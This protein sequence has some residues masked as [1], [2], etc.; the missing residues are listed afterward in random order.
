MSLVTI[1]NMSCSARTTLED[2]YPNLL[3]NNSTNSTNFIKRSGSRAI[4]KFARNVFLEMLPSI[5]LMM[6]PIILSHISPTIRVFKTS[7]K[8]S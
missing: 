6:T 2:L 4:R 8:D 5:S 3:T 7:L 1:S